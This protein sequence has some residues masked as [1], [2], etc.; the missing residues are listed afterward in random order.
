M[1]HEI[2]TQTVIINVLVQAANL[3]LFFWLFNHFFAKKI[4]SGLEERKQLIDKLQNA[5]QEY[6][7]I[8]AQA[9]D[10]AKEIV[11][12][13][14]I[15]KKAMLEETVALAKQKADEII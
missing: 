11:A 5:D 15:R 6:E 7:T 8:V 12:D 3:L 14:N 2:T 13:A 9:N 1:E 10:A 4:V